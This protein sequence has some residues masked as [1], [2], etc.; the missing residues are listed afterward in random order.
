M[1][2][3][4]CSSWSLCLVTSHKSWFFYPYGCVFAMVVIFQTWVLTGSLYWQSQRDLCPLWAIPSFGFFCL[5][6]IYVNALQRLFVFFSQKMSHT[7]F[8]TLNC[9][10]CPSFYQEWK[11]CGQTMRA[12]KHFPFL[13]AEWASTPTR[14]PL[15]KAQII[16]SFGA[17]EVRNNGCVG[18]WI[19]YS[20]NT[21]ISQ[22]Y[23][24]G[25]QVL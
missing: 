9:G 3:F 7:D 5:C 17:G 10:S 21:N 20:V 2:G 8:L 12:Y 11:N 13:Q 14:A 16:L 15:I 6:R 1:A 25:R 19:T 22:Q 23:H 4:L 18:A 24:R